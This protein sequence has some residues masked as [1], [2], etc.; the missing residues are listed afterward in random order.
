MNNTSKMSFVALIIIVISSTQIS[1]TGAT[2]DLE[3]AYIYS[4]RAIEPF[5]LAFD[6]FIKNEG[7]WED[8]IFFI[9]N[10][11]FGRIALSEDSFFLDINLDQSSGHVLKYSFIGANGVEPVGQ[12]VI[13]K[14]TNFLIGD[15]PDKWAIDIPSYSEVLY[16][17]I[18]EGIDLLFRGSDGKLKYEFIINQGA[19]PGDILVEVDGHDDLV[20]KDDLINIQIKNGPDICEDDLRVFY[21]NDIEESINCKFIG[22]N[23]DR[24]S[25][26]LGDFD[27]SRKIVI[28]PLIYSTFVGGTTWDRSFDMHVDSLGNAYVT[29]FCSNAFPITSGAYDTSHNGGQDVAVI[30]LNYSGNS[31]DYSTYIGGT[32]NEYGYGIDVDSS[33]NAYV[34]GYTRSSDF[35]TTSGA[36]DTSIGGTTDGFIVVLNSKGNALSYASYIGGTSSDYAN[37]VKLFGSG[38]AYITGYTYSE[39][40][41][42]SSGAYDTSYD[43]IGDVFVMKISR[44]TGAISYSTLVGGSDTDIGNEI[45]V[46][47]SGNAY[48]GGNTKSSDFPTTLGAY[49]TSKNDG[50]D[51][52]IFKINSAGSSLIYST[53]LGG[54]SSDYIQ[55]IAL[56][57][58]NNATV[59][60][61]TSST[62]FPVTSGA[63]SNSIV[64][65]SD[66]FV[67]NLNITGG[68]LS[69]ST[70][71]GGSGSDT[72]SD[73]DFDSR[74]NIWVSGYTK[75]TNFPMSE[76]SDF[77]INSGGTDSL[78]FKLD[79]NASSLL[80]STYL[81][82]TSNDYSEGIV[83]DSN[84]FVYTTGRVDSTGY[85]T[86]TGAYDT[87]FNGM[88]DW[89]VTKI[90]SDS[91]PD[92]PTGLNATVRSDSIYLSWKVPIS[93]GGSQIIG[94]DI[95]RGTSIGSMSLKYS[96]HPVNFFIDQ[97]VT[98]GTRYYYS[99]KALNLI[100]E[101]DHSNIYL[102]DDTIKPTYDYYSNITH[103]R[104][105]EI[106]V[107]NA[108]V[109][110]DVKLMSVKL[111]FKQESPSFGSI[112][113]VTEDNIN[114]STS[115]LI[116]HDLS[117]V[118]YYFEAQD[119]YLNTNTTEQMEIDIFDYDRPKIINDMTGTIASTGNSF[120]FKVQVL[121]NID[122][123]KVHLE[124]RFGITESSNLTMN[125]I[126]SDTW[127]YGLSI[128]SGSIELIYYSFLAVDTSGNWNRTMEKTVTVKDDDLPIFIEINPIN[129][130]TTGSSIP[131]SIKIIDNIEVESVHLEF[132]FGNGEHQN[133]SLM[134]GTVY[135]YTIDL[136]SDSLSTLF[137]MFHSTDSSGNK[138]SSKIRQVIVL[139]M[140]SPKILENMS[141]DQG[142]TGEIIEIRVRATDN[143]EI[144]SSMLEYWYEDAEHKNVTMTFNGNDEYWKKVALPFR[145]IVP[146]SYKISFV[147]TSQ[148]WFSGDVGEITI[149]DNFIPLI[150]LTGYSQK[151]ETGGSYEFYFEV[152]DNIEISDLELEYWFANTT[153]QKIILSSDSNIF[154]HEISIAIDEAGPL[155]YNV[156]V[157]DSSDNQNI[158]EILN[159][160]IEDIILPEIEPIDDITIY[161]GQD[162]D[163]TITAADNIG[164]VSYSWQGAPIGVDGNQLKGTVTSS[165]D[166][167]ITVT[168]SDEEGN[169]NS[170]VFNLKVL[171]QDHDTDSDGIPDLIEIEWGLSIDDPSDGE[172]DA[173]NDGMSNAL[174]NKNGTLPFNDDTDDDGM[175]DGWEDSH[176]LDP[177]TPSADNDADGDGKTDLQEYQDGTDPLIK[178]KKDDK[179]G[180]PFVIIVILILVILIVIGIVVFL[181]LKKRKGSD[182]PPS[183]NDQ[184]ELEK[185]P[186]TPSEQELGSPQKSQ[187]EGTDIQDR[188][189]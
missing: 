136:P 171:P 143:V 83:V 175:P 51:G 20:V 103:G 145:S 112:D 115:L 111:F 79:K 72:I 12:K 8:H 61:Y 97:N 168:V 177:K 162:V 150:N 163:V 176:G 131:I 27:K 26:D 45:A 120:L 50:Q 68:S 155:F 29:G 124:Y 42:T 6:H 22:I 140:E 3:D 4:G 153:H 35:P 149:I 38:S 119:V 49:D 148:N 62:D 15:D 5:N 108:S 99:V 94:Y 181:I 157:K 87:S 33:G 117:S 67:T 40:F 160:E 109:T 92:S 74:G 127:T 180:F 90:T 158:T 18:W 9:S 137:Y 19:D 91:P 189:L 187:L 57:T 24:Y 36:N 34:A 132:W 23:E 161:E 56:D 121:D 128:P 64:G 63:Y 53:Y 130:S 21:S 25:F 138:N 17:D 89:G 41:Y 88:E 147:D 184:L 84:D 71:I 37:G 169:T 100:G 159:L 174:E 16:E 151:L 113:L 154:T 102:A 139:D 96:S 118:V 98:I 78:V 60:G 156:I 186:S 13:S 73:L 125:M 182:S 123:E 14:N 165:G 116:H 141:T 28:D 173:D 167:E 95:Y 59:A 107:L 93:N 69:Y 188:T 82:G 43:G 66:G 166:Y 44:S 164:I 10:T 48:V 105:G 81:G 54:S 135:S 101:S 178:E 70:L 47:A 1:K 2:T 77:S 170:T 134:G 85:P 122:V 179:G 39:D 110:D 7:Q 133:I 152:W 46:D 11:E 65:N 185:I 58:N 104:T 142:S 75:S 172:A 80:F 106:L 76:D 146:L 52:F 114:W 55:G 183:Q 144:E 86:T 31:L 126:S 30:K 32:G 129:S